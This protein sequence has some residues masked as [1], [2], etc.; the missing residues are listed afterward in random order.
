MQILPVSF[1]MLSLILATG[2]FGCAADVVITASQRVDV[3]VT[4]AISKEPSGQC[5]VQFSLCSL[6][7]TSSCPSPEEYLNQYGTDAP[8]TDFAGKTFLDIATSRIAGGI[9]GDYDPTSDQ[10]SGKQLLLRI[11]REQSAETL[12]VVVRPDAVVEGKQYRVHFI[13]I[14]KGRKISCDEW[15]SRHKQPAG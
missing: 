1:R 15:K 9:N 12:S 13:A 7:P 10:I 4:D 3:V 8:K 6:P 2:S 14:G 11:A 5:N